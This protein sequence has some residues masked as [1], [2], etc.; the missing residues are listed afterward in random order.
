MDNTSDLNSW[1]KIFVRQTIALGAFIGNEPDSF[2]MKL[3]FFDSNLR[4]PDTFCSYW[5]DRW[6]GSNMMMPRSLARIQ[7]NDL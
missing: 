2:R 3:W 6:G 7:Q 1:Y 4:I 5:V